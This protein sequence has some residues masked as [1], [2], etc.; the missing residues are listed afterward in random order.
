MPTP[1][2]T[3]PRRSGL[4][5]CATA[6]IVS[7]FAWAFVGFTTSG[8]TVWHPDDDTSVL[9]I[10]L[11]STIT[12]CAL[13][14]AGLW[15]LALRMM[16]GQHRIADAV[17]GMTAMLITVNRSITEHGDTGRALLGQVAIDR[18]AA[19]Q[20]TASVLGAISE[21]ANSVS[22][23]ADRQWAAGYEARDCDTTADE[24]ELSDAVTAV[25]PLRPRTPHHHHTS[26]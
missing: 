22:E 6:V 18:A 1:R 5:A 12:C 2:L 19:Q 11:A 17:D 3:V 20:R 24:A 23:H 7:L 25:R 8:L 10:N 26:N 21:L 14:G 4:I 9:L 15:W 13:F 16:R